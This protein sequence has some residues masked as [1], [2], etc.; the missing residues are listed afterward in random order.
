MA[1]NFGKPILKIGNK[2]ETSYPGRVIFNKVP[3]NLSARPTLIFDVNAS[4][5]ANQDAEVSY[6]TNGISWR[7]DY[8][9]EVNEKNSL[10]LNGLVTLTNNTNVSYKNGETYEDGTPMKFGWQ[11]EAEPIL[12]AFEKVQREHISIIR[13]L[14][15]PVICF[16]I[17]TFFPVY[18]AKYPLYRSLVQCVTFL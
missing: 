1:Y 5:M 10:D 9:I 14:F 6:L 18:T 13:P 3:E 8:V 12:E 7:A 4:N 15:Y 17:I 16:Y 11:L 2:I